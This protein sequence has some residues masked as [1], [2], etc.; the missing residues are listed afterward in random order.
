MKR[1]YKH[2]VALRLDFLGRGSV[3][4]VHS[5]HQYSV[6]SSFGSEKFVSNLG[7][8]TCFCNFA[9]SLADIYRLHLHLLYFCSV[10]FLFVLKLMVERIPKELMNDEALKGYFEKLFP[11]RVHSASVLLKLPALEILSQK[12]EKT[13]K[14]LE[15]SIAYFESTGVKSKHF[16]RCFYFCYKTR[17]VQE[18]DETMT[19]SFDD[20]KKRQQVDSITYYTEEL[21]SI[22]REML[23][24]QQQRA[25][26]AECGNNSYHNTTWFS[27]I[28]CKVGKSAGKFI[29]DSDFDNGLHTSIKGVPSWMDD[30]SK[31]LKNGSDNKDTVGRKDGSPSGKSMY[32]Y[33]SLD[34]ETE[35]NRNHRHYRKQLKNRDKST[36]MTNEKISNLH[37]KD[38]EWYTKQSTSQSHRNQPL[39][40]DR[41][42][43]SNK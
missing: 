23:M 13:L 43:V 42:M 29:D 17:S 5:Q 19:N 21:M 40:T 38:A 4:G 34:C 15:K 39:F 2:Y 12:K 18:M 28:Q 14:R 33:G 24:L 11:D 3:K 25:K 9:L 27:T 37:L 26:S 36:S 22:N 31:K 6:S 20:K 41:F 8:V 10:F 7:L 16:P 1:E 32:M 30:A 35:S